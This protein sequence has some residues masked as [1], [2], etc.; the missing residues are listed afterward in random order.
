MS[1]ALVSV[2]SEVPLNTS[3]L[4]YFTGKSC[5]IPIDIHADL[6]AFLA[7]DLGEIELLLNE[8]DAFLASELQTTCSR[9]AKRIKVMC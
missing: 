2:G 1:G 4:Q 6:E 8:K 9:E 3:Y 7:P 5:R